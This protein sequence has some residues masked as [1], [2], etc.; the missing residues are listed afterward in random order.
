MMRRYMPST[1]AS[2]SA[3]WTLRSRSFGVSARCLFDRV[4]R[5]LQPIDHLGLGGDRFFHALFKVRRHLGSGNAQEI[6]VLRLRCAC[7]LRWWSGLPARAA[8]RICLRGWLRPR[9]STAGKHVSTRRHIPP[10]CPR[11]RTGRTTAACSMK[12]TLV[13][14][15]IVCSRRGSSRTLDS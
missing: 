15:P 6:E 2:R 7:R 14:V 4:Q 5:A 11:A 8:M 3:M 1:V 13:F 10:R 12:T 9:L